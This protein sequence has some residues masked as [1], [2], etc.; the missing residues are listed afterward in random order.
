[1]RHKLAWATAVA[2]GITA[3]VAGAEPVQLTVTIENLAPRN[4]TFQ[5][6]H[7]VAFHDGSFDIYNGGTPA[8]SLPIPGSEGVERLAEDGNTG[9][10]TMDFEI[11]V[12]GGVVATMAGPNG[13]IAPGEVAT[14]TF[15]LE[16]TDP[17]ARFFSYASMVIPSNDF[18]YANGDPMAIP[19][20]DEAGN[21]VAQDFIVTN[22]RIL[23]AGTEVN[24]ELPMN[25]AF[26]GQQMPDTGV[27][28]NGVI[29]DFGDPSGL[30]MFMPPEEGGILADPGFAG[31]DFALDGY[32]LVK[33]SFATGVAAADEAF[34]RG[35]YLELLGFEPDE[36]GLMFWV[37]ALQ[38]G[39]SRDAATQ[40]FMDAA[41][42]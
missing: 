25:T 30:V 29:L 24:D 16:S 38:D 22:Q 2:G 37:E 33:I 28:E 17:N 35:L 15:D 26:F 10:L 8:D 6:P 4:G 42:G 34:V 21:F 13:P 14:M 9:V 27:E 40:A 11:L 32:P 1:M 18:W 19:V 41:G 12:P 7:F 23:D 3:V 39:L 20:F 31:A 5:T 36:A